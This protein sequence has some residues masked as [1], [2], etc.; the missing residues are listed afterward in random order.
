MHTFRLHNFSYSSILVY[1]GPVTC[2]NQGTVRA[3][4]ADVVADETDDHRMLTELPGVLLHE[5]SE[6]LLVLLLFLLLLMLLKLLLIKLAT[7]ACF[8]NFPLFSP[9]GSKISLL[10]FI[11]LFSLVAYSL[12]LK[13]K[14]L[15]PHCIQPTIYKRDKER[16]GINMIKN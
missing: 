13:I 14:H 7:N 10:L 9:L 11:K 4:D 15:Q 5:G 1:F 12:R 3:P 6:K 2:S 8:P 16:V